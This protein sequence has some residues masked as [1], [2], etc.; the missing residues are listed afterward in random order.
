MYRNHTIDLVN[1][2]RSAVR[3]LLIVGRIYS[4]ELYVTDVLN[5]A[6]NGYLGT[7]ARFVFGFRPES[8]RRPNIGRRPEY[9]V[10][11]TTNRHE[12]LPVFAGIP[13]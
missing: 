11:R 9:H 13:V 7:R 5:K 1:R 8:G 6:A 2:F 4:N 12:N 10:Y 3:I